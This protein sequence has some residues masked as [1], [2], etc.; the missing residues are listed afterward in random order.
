M[1]AA[2]EREQIIEIVGEALSARAGSQKPWREDI[3][4]F[5]AD[6]SRA[7]L[8]IVPTEQG[9]GKPV[10]W[11]FVG[12]RVKS[13]TARVEFLSFTGEEGTD[14]WPIDQWE[15]Y[16]WAPLGH[17]PPAQGAR[18]AEDGRYSQGLCDDGVAILYDGQPITVDEIVAR[19]NRLPTSTAQG[20]GEDLISRDARLGALVR[21]HIV[22]HHNGWL[23]N[24]VFVTG[25]PSVEELD[26][27]IASI[28]ESKAT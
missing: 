16:T 20:A 9:A 12:K 17:L 2:T 19:L 8:S 3:A 15:R 18:E 5:L 25:S 11:L 7:G 27:C 4:D 21:P 6:L 22:T 23:I 24:Q 28:A 1:T 26:D 10:G 13:T 14:H